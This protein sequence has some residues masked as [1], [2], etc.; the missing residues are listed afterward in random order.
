MYMCD[1]PASQKQ[2]PLERLALGQGSAEE[3]AETFLSVFDDLC[4]AEEAQPQ[5]RCQP[6]RMLNRKNTC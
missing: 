6:T 4:H 5:G 2:A 1:M 3:H